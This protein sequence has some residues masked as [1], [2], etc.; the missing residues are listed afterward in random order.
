MT[1]REFLERSGSSMLVR[2]NMM[3][4]VVIVFDSDYMRGIIDDILDLEVETF[5]IDSVYRNKVNCTVEA[6]TGETVSVSSIEMLTRAMEDESVKTVRLVTDI[7]SN[8]RF[9]VEL[10]SGEKTLD[11]NSHALIG[12]SG[13]TTQS[14][15]AI[16]VSG[17]TLTILGDAYSEVDGGEGS[18]SNVAVWAYGA[19]SKI[20]IEG[21]NYNVGNDKDGD[22]NSTIYAEAGA[23]IEIH[24][25][26]FR[27]NGAVSLGK[28]G[29]VLNIQNNSG[30]YIICSGGLYVNQN[31]AD[32]DDKDTAT[33]STFL[34]DGCTV[35]SWEE[36]G[37]MYYTVE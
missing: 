9:G 2:V 27:N 16:H 4:E 37:I 32:G 11:L 35:S 18:S 28:T 15:A 25:G 31:P 24:D 1:V 3:G 5:R 21:G 26:E 19:D 12:V 13:D 29:Q 34:A 20:I 8:A 6:V 33:G 17:G 23:T 10:T 22:V 36:E 7:E 14:T 30:S